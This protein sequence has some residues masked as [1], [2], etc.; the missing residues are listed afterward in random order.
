MDLSASFR[1]KLES[2][3][4]DKKILVHKIRKSDQQKFIFADKEAAT[5]VAKELAH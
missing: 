5:W 3:G 4:L 2:S 1:L